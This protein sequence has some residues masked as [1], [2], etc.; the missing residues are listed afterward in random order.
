[1][2]KTPS[3]N[4]LNFFIFYCKRNFVVCTIAYINN[5][6]KTTIIVNLKDVAI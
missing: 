6:V 1:M 4:T 5:S 3:L 2:R